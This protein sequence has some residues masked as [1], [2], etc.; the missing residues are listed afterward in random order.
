MFGLRNFIVCR[1]FF[2]FPEGSETINN[3][4]LSF[5]LLRN[6]RQ[7]KNNLTN[8]HENTLTNFFKERRDHLA[9]KK[10]EAMGS[11]LGSY[12]MGKDHRS[13]RR[14][15]EPNSRNKSNLAKRKNHN[16]LAYYRFG[17]S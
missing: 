3:F 8:L 4:I 2:I 10:K 5:S 9:T 17:N 6:Q 11:Y 15:L 16:F 7:V 14:V 12:R 1:V 13:W